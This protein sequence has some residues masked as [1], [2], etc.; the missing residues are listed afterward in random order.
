MS[1]RTRVKDKKSILSTY[2][3]IKLWNFDDFFGSKLNTRSFDEYCITYL[4]YNMQ[5]QFNTQ[6]DIEYTA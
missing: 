5:M 2:T 4:K 6:N 1:L 3:K